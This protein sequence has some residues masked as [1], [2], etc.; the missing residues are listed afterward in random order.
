[1]LWLW[2]WLFVSD[3]VLVWVAFGLGWHRSTE[4]ALPFVQ[5]LQELLLARDK[6]ITE[7]QMETLSMHNE[8]ARYRKEHIQPDE[9]HARRCIEGLPD[10]QYWEVLDQIKR[11]GY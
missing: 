1:M 2:V 6:T 8:L 7:L 11:R 4:H 3:L 10:E 9:F 5:R